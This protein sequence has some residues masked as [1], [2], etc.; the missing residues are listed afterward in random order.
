ML[1]AGAAGPVDLHLNVLL[2]DLHLV[3]IL[4]LGH[5]LHRGKAGL[6]AGVGIKG[7]H[8]DQP[9]DAVLTLQKAVGV[10]PLDGDGRGFDAR[11]V[12]VLIVQDLVDKAVALGPAGVHP[13][14]H[15]GPVLGLGAAGAGVDGQDGVGVVIL[16]G[17]QGGEAGLL[18]VGLQLGKAL[19]QLGQEGVVLLLIAHL[20]QGHQVGPLIPAA[21]LALQLALEL[22]DALL[23]LLGLLQV[24]PEAVGGALRLEH[25]Y[26]TGGGLQPQGLVQIVQVGHD[27][28]QFYLI[29]VKLKHDTHSHYLMM[30]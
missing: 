8:P 6:P 5:D 19:L 20:A 18:N 3:V 28:I 10:I 9:V 4:D 15:L 27:V 16:P 24:V 13:V 14:E 7:R 26:L 21:L 12:A 25:L 11:L 1:A 23:D 2:P 30:V 17:E 22:G 29:F